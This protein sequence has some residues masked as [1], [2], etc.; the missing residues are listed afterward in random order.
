VAFEIG[1]LRDWAAGDDQVDLLVSNAVL[2]WVP[3][4]LE[5]LPA[6]A[7]RVRPGGVMAIQ[8]PGNEGAPSQVLRRQLAARPPYA[9]H[10]AGIEE[11]SSHDPADYLDVL[12]TRG[13]T[14]D[15]WTTT[16]LHVLPGDDPVFDWFAGTGLRPTLQALPDDLR[17][18][19]EAELKAL[20]R[21]AFPRHD[22][23]TVMPF[24]RVFVVARR[25]G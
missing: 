12:A 21:E 10:L 13:W 17:P 25:D 16:Y 8:V 11:I 15:T 1:D 14:V 22:Y 19:F 2:Q 9:D 24:R 20:L 3:E 7:A 4:H 5:L 23:G 6:I 18:Q